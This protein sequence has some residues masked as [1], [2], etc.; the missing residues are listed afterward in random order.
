M[1][2]IDNLVEFGNENVVLDFKLNEYPKQETLALIKDV[3]AMAN[4]DVVG[5]RYIIIGMKPNATGRGI[6][7]LSSLRDP[8]TFQQTVLDNIVPDIHL[9]Y[10]PHHTSDNKLLGIIRIYNCNA[11]PYLMKKD[12]IYLK[13]GQGFIRKETTQMEL[14]HSDY[15]QI[16]FQRYDAKK[17]SGDLSVAFNKTMSEKTLYSTPF[18]PDNLQFPS[19]IKKKNIEKLIEVKEKEMAQDKRIGLEHNED[20][21]SL[22]STTAIAMANLNRTSI[23]YEHRSLKTLRI[24]LTNVKETYHNEDYHY[25]FAFQSAKVNF[26]IQNLGKTFLEDIRVIIKI[27]KENGFFISKLLPKEYTKETDLKTNFNYP[28]VEENETIYEVSENIGDIH[29]LL[30]CKVFKEPLRIAFHP[31]LSGKTITLHISF[32]GKNLITPIEKTLE[33]LITNLDN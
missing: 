6:I 3:L 13:K 33:I 17:F 4:A 19:D 29:Q 15:E 30:P 18:N 16:Y 25:L 28:L 24:N 7:G 5:D 32:F 1:T 22:Y 20:Y 31:K 9:D 27:A 10:T 8:A 2:E 26:Y 12:Y 23:S 21:L 14:Q 11:R